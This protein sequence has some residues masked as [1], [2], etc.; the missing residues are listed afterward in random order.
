MVN[1]NEVI[2]VIL[3]VIRCFITRAVRI[4]YFPSVFMKD[5]FMIVSGVF[6]T[7]GDELTER[8]HVYLFS[9]FSAKEKGRNKS[10]PLEVDRLFRPCCFPDFYI[11]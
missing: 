11:R 2:P 7:F 10:G 1:V 5:F 9:V 3:M 8:K 4:G 6:G